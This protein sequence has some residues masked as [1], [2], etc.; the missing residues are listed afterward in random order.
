M[1]TAHVRI[2]A[3][4][5]GVR[6]ADLD[7]IHQYGSETKD[8]LIMTRRDIAIVE[9]EIKDLLDRLAKLDGVFVATDG[10]SMITTFRPTKRQHRAQFG[11]DR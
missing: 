10:E 8:G 11:G 5:R 6:E 7:L 9:R 2:R 4:Q 3:Q 1:L